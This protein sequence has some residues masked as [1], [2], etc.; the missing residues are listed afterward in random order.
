MKKKMLSG[1]IRLGLHVVGKCIEEIDVDER[2]KM[3]SEVH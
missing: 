2:M 3:F 1:A